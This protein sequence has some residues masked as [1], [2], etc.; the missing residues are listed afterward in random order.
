[1]SLPLCRLRMLFWLCPICTVT[2]A[3]PVDFRVEQAGRDSRGRV[4]CE[5]PAEADSYYL[6]LRGPRPDACTFP[7]DLSLGSRLYD[8]VP[9]LRSAF[10][11]VKRV[12]WSQ[13]LDTDGDMS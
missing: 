8:S 11:Q 10:F 9:A 7:A 3:P 2:A 4:F 1:M 12:P 6:L 13:S 5:V